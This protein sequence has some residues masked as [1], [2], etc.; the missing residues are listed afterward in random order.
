MKPYYDDGQSVIYHGKCEEIMP[1]LEQ[2]DMVFISPPYNLSNT[3]G[4]GFNTRPKG[5]WRKAAIQRGY[6]GQAD[7]MPQEEYEEWQRACLRLCWAQLSDHGAIYY[8]HKPRGKNGECWLPLTLNPGLPLR[9][10]VIWA[11]AGGMNYTPTHYVSTCEWILVLAKPA[12]RLKNQAASGVGD[13][14]YVPQQLRKDHPAP[15]PVGL[16]ARAIESVHPSSVL[17][18]FAGS[19]TTLVAA[20]AAGVH[21]VGIEQS[22]Q[23]CENAAYRLQQGV[24]L[25]E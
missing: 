18:P 5:K 19:G 22:E 12:F 23:Y 4:G 10:V 2:V 25:L 3:P 1:G 7:A 17:D 8:N 16:P 21:C 9:Q 6:D 14:W 11:R 15:F 20:K 24:L 13:V